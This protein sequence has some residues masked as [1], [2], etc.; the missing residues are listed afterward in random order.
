MSRSCRFLLFLPHKYQVTYFTLELYSQP[1]QCVVHR[2]KSSHYLQQECLS[3]NRLHS[4]NLHIHLF[5]PLVSLG[6]CK[7]G[8]GILDSKF[9]QTRDSGF[10][11]Q[12][13]QDS[14][15]RLL[16]I[17]DSGI[18]IS[19]QFSGIHIS[20]WLGFRIQ[21]SNR[22]DSGFRFGRPGPYPCK[23]GTEFSLYL[24]CPLPYIM[25]AP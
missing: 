14:G 23:A 11:F 20:K 4:G 1:Y 19:K 7:G 25:T 5:P 22:W 17:K 24:H 3:K 8:P 12:K 13:G 21:I 6:P 10:K 9:K 16:V 15:F 18:Q 2:V